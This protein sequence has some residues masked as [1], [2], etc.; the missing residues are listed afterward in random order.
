M[1]AV[2]LAVLLSAALVPAATAAEKGPL[3]AGLNPG[4]RPGPYSALVS[5]GPERGQLHCYVCE[6][7]DRPAVIVFARSL[8]DP[9]GTL[10]GGLDRAVRDHKADGLR[11]WVT[12]LADDQ[13]ALDPQLVKWGQRYAVRAVP[14]AVFEDAA[15]PPA[16]RLQRD[17]DVTVLLAVKQKVLRAY[18][19]RAGELT[20]ARIAL[21]VGDLVKIT[22][23]AK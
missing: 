12:F 11:A 7:A 19:F 9:L 21:V 6:T 4:Q 16:Y 14:L 8:S 3:A 22:G 23:A 2:R 1:H 20:D 15:G 5:V 10:V 18:A 13:P 17:A